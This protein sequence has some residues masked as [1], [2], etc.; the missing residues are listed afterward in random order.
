MGK[1]KQKD[2][3]TVE[4]GFATQA[5]SQWDSRDSKTN[6]AIPNDAN[7]TRAKNWVDENQK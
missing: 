6:M 1:K 7:V 4:G 3:V 2:K 5:I